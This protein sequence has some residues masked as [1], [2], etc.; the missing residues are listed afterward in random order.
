L[1]AVIDLVKEDLGE[2]DVRP[3]RILTMSPFVEPR[4]VHIEKE[5]SGDRLEDTFNIPFERHLE[6]RSGH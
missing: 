2:S 6:V 1:Q 5:N 4:V 3:N